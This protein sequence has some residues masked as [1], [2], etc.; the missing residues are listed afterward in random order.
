[1]FYKL[2][3]QKQELPRAVSEEKNLEESTNQKQVLP[4]A[5]LFVNGSERKEHFW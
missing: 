5:V 2:T 3:S 1:M 4:M